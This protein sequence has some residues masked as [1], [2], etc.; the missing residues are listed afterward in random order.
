MTGEG[1]L[2]SGVAQNVSTEFLKVVSVS[3]SVH[4]TADDSTKSHFISARGATE[5][6]QSE[7]SHVQMLLNVSHDTSRESCGSGQMLTVVTSIFVIK[8]K[9]C[10]N[11]K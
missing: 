1:I 6:M 8:K 11:E 5:L 3:I 4:I 10:Q 9:N 7:E 2:L